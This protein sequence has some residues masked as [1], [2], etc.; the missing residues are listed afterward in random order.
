MKSFI[1][2]MDGTLFQTEKILE[3]SLEDTFNQLRAIELWHEET[4]IETYR[5]IMGVPLPVVWETLLP[6]QSCE[7]RSKAND[8][9]QEHLIA[10]IRKGNGLLYPHVLE[11]FEFFREKNI[12]IFIASNGLSEYLRAIVDYYELDQ[13]V[14]ETFSIQ[15]ISTQ[16]KTDLVRY[17]IKKHN[18]TNGAVVG[19]R[20]SDI[21][22]AK[23][24][25]LFAVGCN[26]DFAQENELSQ[27]DIVIDDLQELKTLFSEQLIRNK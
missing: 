6:Y 24:N 7:I 5:L 18:I 9:F 11:V 4:P 13:W 2:D 21:M 20:L 8:L 19:D 27:A 26:F 3:G 16:N 25:N 22:A 14:T 12:P 1:F 15:Q 10:N 17:I 23:E